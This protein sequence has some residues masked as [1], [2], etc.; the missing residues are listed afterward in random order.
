MGCLVYRRKEL[1]NVG[2]GYNGGE[3]MSI[4]EYDKEAT[5]TQR[6]RENLFTAARSRCL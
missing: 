2:T 4:T 5:E 6:H 3:S 1:R